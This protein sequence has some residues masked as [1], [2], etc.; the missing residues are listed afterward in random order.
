[1]SGKIPIVAAVFP[2]C[3]A[4]LLLSSFTYASSPEFDWTHSCRAPDH[5]LL[6]HELAFGPAFKRVAVSDSGQ[7]RQL[8]L[9]YFLPNDRTFN[10]DVVDSMK[11]RISRIRTFFLNQMQSN[12]KGAMTFGYE[13]DAQ[14]DPIV[15]RFDAPNSDASYLSSYRMVGIGNVFRDLGSTFD[16]S[17]NIFFI[18]V[19]H[20]TYNNLGWGNVA[21]F[22]ARWADNRGYA[23]LPASFI[24]ETAAHELGHAFGLQHEFNDGANIMS[25]GPGWN[26][27]A[28]CSAGLLSVH[29]YFN[30]AIPIKGYQGG[31][32]LG[33][34]NSPGVELIS[35]LRYP[36]GATSFSVQFRV[37]ATGSRGLHQV[38]FFLKTK[39][40]HAAAGSQE[41][42]S[43]RVFTGQNQAVATF[44]YDGIVPSEGVS[45]LSASP[46]QYVSVLAV[47]TE[48]NA[49]TGPLHD[50]HFVFAEASEHHLA[51]L[52]RFTGKYS[53]EIYGAKFSTDGSVLAVNSSA[54]IQLWNM[55][56][57]VHTAS[58]RGGSSTAAF[59][60][61]GATLASGS[62]RTDEAN[63]KLWNVA[64]QTLIATLPGHTGG[65]TGV[66]SLAFSPS[67]D[68]L[69]SGSGDRT[70][71]LWDVSS[72]TLITTLTGHTSHVFAIAYSPDGTLASGS[73]DGTVKLWNTATRTNIATLQGNTGRVLDVAFSPDGTTLASSTDGPMVLWDVTA[74]DTIATL[75]G[76]GR[77]S[78]SSDGSMLATGAGLGEVLLWDVA[79]TENVARLGHPDHLE[80]GSGFGING[81]F[82][83]DGSLLASVG[84]NGIELWDASEWTGASPPASTPANPDSVALV[85]L[86]N[87][88]SGA[89][90]RSRTNWLS[91]KPLDE[92]K[93]VSTTGT[94]RVNNLSLELNR[95]SGP[96]PAGIG[97]LSFLVSLYL[98]SN[99]L[100]GALPPEVGN[101]SNLVHLEIYRNR[102]SGPIP[103][104]LGNLSRLTKL[105]LHSNQLTG[106][107]PAELGN[108]T[109]LTT[110][111]LANN[112]LTGSIP[113]ELD[114]LTN[115]THLYLSGNPLK[116]CIPAGLR[117][118]ATNDLDQVGLPY[119]G[120]GQTQTS[121]D[122]NG[123]GR[124]DFVDFFLF[125]DAYGST[126]AKFDLDGN[127]TVDFADFFKFVDAFGS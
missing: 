24:V 63:I 7:T 81:V 102:L 8:R 77:P 52:F 45:S 13:T 15:H 98:Y 75:Q 115:L 76:H 6:G 2:A 84:L 111:S 10:P 26:R 85:A 80:D 117:D 46:A 73:R 39:S 72:R 95:L 40:P 53:P 58:L 101:L 30:P 69:A 89:N 38:V 21:G 120:Q 23:L 20:S 82:S 5:E 94:G 91:D 67:G 103:S 113:A 57:R 127:G 92:W 97:N 3:L 35:P 86:Y 33:A 55:T 49:N 114:S 48:G 37:T 27:L 14:G 106:S 68:T 121:T 16:T 87:A 74:R 34:F 90:W 11:A 83:P 43:C 29:P 19:D 116:G 107:I 17:Q 22:G 66:H 64:D 18:V 79:T 54:G 1:M 88:T 62:T 28:A 41:V 104:E 109:S 110:L 9:V 47:D 119:C 59:S 32:D 124:T 126:N 125:A 56:S 12:G 4:I 25:Y 122:F 71:K 61:D 31:Y 112:R 36:A 51:T 60:P 50:T 108:L 93:G 105:N 42:K 78:F 65:P 44:D 70:I 123:D 96:I 118:V 100:S 99:Q